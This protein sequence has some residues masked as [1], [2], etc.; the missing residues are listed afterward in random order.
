MLN[1]EAPKVGDG[2]AKLGGGVNSEDL[3]YSR[4]SRRRHAEDQAQGPGGPTAPAV[5]L[6]EE[7]LKERLIQLCTGDGERPAATSGLCSMAG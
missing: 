3:P 1:D 2:E 4:S 6:S 5:V 7:E